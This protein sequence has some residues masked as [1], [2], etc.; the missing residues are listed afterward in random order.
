MISK[1]SAPWERHPPG[2][3]AAW[4][5]SQLR[6]STA[7]GWPL[8]AGGKGCRQ[9]CWDASTRTDPLPLRA[10]LSWRSAARSHLHL[11]YSPS[12]I[13]VPMGTS[14]GPI[15]PDP[16]LRPTDCLPNLT[17]DL[18]RHHGL[19]WQWECWAVISCPTPLLGLVGQSLASRVLALL[20]MPSLSAP[21]PL[22]RREQEPLP[23]AVIQLHGFL[24]CQGP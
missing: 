24:P 18:P 19:A 9:H 2:G 22:T 13:I 4:A 21:S 23:D 3:S 15:N 5:W 6:D 17:L 11:S 16:H 1:V 10:A 7:E 14:V 12:H 8:P 20:T